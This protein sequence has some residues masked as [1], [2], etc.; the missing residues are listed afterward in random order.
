MNIRTAIS[1]DASYISLLME[2]LGYNASSSSL[3]E[4]KLLKFSKTEIDEVFEAEIGGVIVGLISCHITSL[5]HQRGS[6]GRITS[7]TI[8]QKHRGSRVGKSLVSQAERFFQSHNCVKF[9]ITCRDHRP[10]AHAFY[11]SCGYLEDE[12][13]FIKLYS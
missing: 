4:E 6:S 3:I 8:D 7:L 1:D 11:K 9:E 2:Q 10:E 13:R 12:R 5:F